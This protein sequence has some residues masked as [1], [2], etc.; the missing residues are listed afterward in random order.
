VSFENLGAF[1]QILSCL[2][3]KFSIVGTEA[4]EGHYEGVDKDVNLGGGEV[5]PLIN[6][7]LLEDAGTVE[8]VGCSCNE[9]EDGVAL[10]KVSLG[11]GEDWAFSKGV[12]G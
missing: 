8:F 5:Q 3:G 11:G 10:E 2:G 4:K 6:E 7:A 1:S 12:T 9:S